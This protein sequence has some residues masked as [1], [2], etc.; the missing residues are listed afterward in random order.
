MKD[1]QMIVAQVQQKNQEQ[2]NMLAQSIQPFFAAL[3]QKR[4]YDEQY[5]RTKR[6]ADEKAQKFNVDLQ[7]LAQVS[8]VDM[9]A[10]SPTADPSIQMAA[11]QQNLATKTRREDTI[12]KAQVAGFGKE[13]E[14]RFA[15]DPNVDIDVAYSEILNMA[16]EREIG[17]KAELLGSKYSKMFKGKLA[18]GLTTREA[19]GDTIDQ[20]NLDEL[21]QKMAIADA[22]EQKKAAA[23]DGTKPATF[24]QR[25]SAQK[26]LDSAKTTRTK[27]TN[28]TAYNI[29][30]D[31]DEKKALV[32]VGYIEVLG[33]K[34]V[35]TMEID[36]TYYAYD[37]H[38]YYTYN[39]GK[40]DR[41]WKPA[42]PE[43][44]PGNALMGQRLADFLATEKKITA[45]N[46]VLSM[47]HDTEGWQ[48]QEFNNAFSEF[49]EI[50]Q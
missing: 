32:K 10:I 5:E 20:K 3:Q 37:G 1:F 43:K 14:E 23:G 46:N 8:G 7:S 29:K 9:P 41:G 18:N 16:D 44:I 13:I 25:V 17:Q 39:K 38:K 33:N 30:V 45:A 49:D 50:F 19:Y 6:E 21:Y 27:L 15:A 47:T 22:Q 36:G 31:K 12:N 35:A 28:G 42:S 40:K 34:P 11:L 48:N 26:L 4:A 24:P 2:R